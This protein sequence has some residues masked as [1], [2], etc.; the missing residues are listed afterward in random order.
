MANFTYVALNK[1]GKEVKGTI[2]AADENSARAKLKALRPSSVG[3]ASRI[4]G[5]SPADISV[6]L[7]YLEHIKNGNK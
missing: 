7:V 6:L 1:Q 2:D 3:Q 5:V 4:S